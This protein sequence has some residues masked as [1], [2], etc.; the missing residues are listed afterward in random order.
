MSPAGSEILPSFGTSATPARPLQAVTS[1]MTECSPST[2]FDTSPGA[3]DMT[4]R[5]L[6]ILVAI[7]LVTAGLGARQ[8]QPP[9]LTADVLKGLRASQHRPG[10]DHRPHRRRRDRSEEPERLV[11]RLGVRRPLEDDE[12][13]H[14]L[15]ADLRRQRRLHALLRR[16]RSE[17]LERPLARHRGEQQPAQRALRRRHLQ[18]DR[19]RQDVEADGARDLRA[20]RRRF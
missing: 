17:G 5:T 6:L 18:V 16:H 9:R 15:R 2:P 14:H 4:R 3:D 8:S 19:R 11:R 7:G 10:A 13:R 1:A 20:H 12:P